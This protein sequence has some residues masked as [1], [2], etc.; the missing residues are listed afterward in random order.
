VCPGDRS[1]DRQAESHPTFTARARDVAA[2][3][4]L[5]DVVDGLGVD[6]LAAVRDGDHDVVA[7]TVRGELD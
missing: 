3:E 6:A 7:L 4:T 2:C 1:D 5:E